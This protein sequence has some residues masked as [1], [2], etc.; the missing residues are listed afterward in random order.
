MTERIKDAERSG[1]PAKFKP[2]QILQ[3]FKLACDDLRDYAR[4]LNVVYFLNPQP[5]PEDRLYPFKVRMPTS[6]LIAFNA[7]F[8][9]RSQSSILMR[10]DF[11]WLEKP[12][13]YL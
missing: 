2:A 3:L 1:A 7:D 9:H 6:T 13:G 5:L 11:A 8:A 10:L 12:S 4:P